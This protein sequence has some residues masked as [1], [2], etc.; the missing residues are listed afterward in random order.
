MKKGVIFMLD[1]ND[2]DL[3]DALETISLMD[4]YE[5]E[6]IRLEFEN[7]GYILKRNKNESGDTNI[8]VEKK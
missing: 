8:I 6:K 5:F 3:F 7:N 1:Y 4:D 2:L